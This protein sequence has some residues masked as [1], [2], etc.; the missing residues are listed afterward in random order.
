MP[1]RAYDTRC[2]T[3]AVRSKIHYFVHIW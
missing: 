2:P 1:G 3:T